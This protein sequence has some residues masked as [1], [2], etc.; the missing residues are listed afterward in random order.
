MK[1][2]SPASVAPI[3]DETMRILESKHPSNSF[4]DH[5]HLVRDF[6][7]KG[8]KF[9]KDEITEVIKKCPLGFASGPDGPLYEHRLLLQL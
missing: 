9:T 5:S 7:I 2:L 6:T 8:H 3:T 4:N 1:S